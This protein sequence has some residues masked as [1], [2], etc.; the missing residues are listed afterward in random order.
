MKKVS[1]DMMLGRKTRCLYKKSPAKTLIVRANLPA[2]N[3]QKVPI[4]GQYGINSE[5]FCTTFNQ[6]STQIFQKNLV[7]PIIIVIPP[8]KQY[9][10]EYNISTITHL[11]DLVFSLDK[12]SYTYFQANTP[13]KL[14]LFSAYKMSALKSNSVNYRDRW[15]PQIIGSL[16]SC[17]MLSILRKVKKKFNYKKK[18][19]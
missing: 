18:Q 13:R 2:G 11:L 15:M 16:R 3:V 14:F 6:Y 5:Q 1:L 9:V 17:N 10:I 7:I 4:L 12:R 19:K 8:S